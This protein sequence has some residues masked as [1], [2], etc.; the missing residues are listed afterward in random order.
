VKLLEVTDQAL[1]IEQ[2]Q[3]MLGQW[4]STLPRPFEDEH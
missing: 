1:E 3:R 4:R 2:L